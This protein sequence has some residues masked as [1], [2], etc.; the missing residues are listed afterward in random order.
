MS[1]KLLNRLMNKSTPP[2]QAVASQDVRSSLFNYPQPQ[3]VQFIDGTALSRIESNVSALVSEFRKQNENTAAL[4]AALGEFRDTLI[5]PLREELKNLRFNTGARVEQSSRELELITHHLGKSVRAVLKAAGMTPAQIDGYLHEHGIDFD[6]QVR[7]V[8]LNT[9]VA[10]IQE[11]REQ[12]QKTV[13]ELAQANLR[14]KELTTVMNAAP[15]TGVHEYRPE[16]NV[17]VGTNTT[18]AW[19]TQTF[20]ASNQGPPGAP[21]IGLGGLLMNEGDVISFV[22]GTDATATTRCLVQYSVAPV[23][24][25]LVK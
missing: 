12:L 7:N 23:V 5:V 22:N 16:E 6:N 2:Q 19:G 20:T 24:G 11:L 9:Y 17:W 3:A 1:R 8:D 13:T 21:G 25:N 4:N 10:T 15:Q 14:I 18:Q